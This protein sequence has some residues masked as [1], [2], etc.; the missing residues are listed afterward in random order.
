MDQPAWSAWAGRVEKVFRA[1]VSVYSLYHARESICS[2]GVI[3]K[4]VA[5]IAGIECFDRQ[6]LRVLKEIYPELI[7]Y[8]YVIQDA[9]PT[10]LRTQSNPSSSSHPPRENETHTDTKGTPH[11]EQERGVL[12]REGG[13]PERG[14]GRVELGGG[15]PLE[16]GGRRKGRGIWFRLIYGFSILTLSKPS[17]SLLTSKSRRIDRKTTRSNVNESELAGAT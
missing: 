11:L 16:G 2:L 4:T 7:S 13:V 15:D 14:E 10:R 6:T 1:L 3:G 5:K 12:E 17:K 9:S 8:K